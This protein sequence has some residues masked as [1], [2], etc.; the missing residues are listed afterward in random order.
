MSKCLFWNP[1]RKVSSLRYRSSCYELSYKSIH[2]CSSSKSRCTKPL[3][4]WNVRKT[5]IKSPNLMFCK[6]QIDRQH[7]TYIGDYSVKYQMNPSNH[8]GVLSP[9]VQNL[10]SLKSM[11][12][13]HKISVFHFFQHLNRCVSFLGCRASCCKISDESM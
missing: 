1:N 13:H 7:P 4:R 8:V 12:N 10:C 5:A 11:K 2:P 9:D 6:I 3:F